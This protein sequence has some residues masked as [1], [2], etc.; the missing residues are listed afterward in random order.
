MSSET[1]A[2]LR[3][4]LVTPAQ[5]LAAFEAAELRIP[6]SEGE[7]GVLPGHQVTL[8]TLR[9]GILTVRRAAGG[10]VEEYVIGQG[11]VDVSPAAVTVLAEEAVAR[12]D[13]NTAKSQQQLT[14][15]E[16]HIKELKALGDTQAQPVEL[17]RAERDAEVLRIKLALATGGTD[18]AEAEAAHGA[19]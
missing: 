8:S 10:K 19:A 18:A 16:K 12:A 15:L 4:E 14:A 5:R 2:T 11:F 9:P 13:I 17:A 7:F 3:F 6:G 1:Q